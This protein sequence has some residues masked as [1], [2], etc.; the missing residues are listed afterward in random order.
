MLKHTRPS[1]TRLSTSC[2]SCSSSSYSLPHG[3]FLESIVL[4]GWHRSA[5]T[6]GFLTSTPRSRSRP[7]SLSRALCATRALSSSASSGTWVAPP[8]RVG[9]AR[10]VGCLSGQECW[11]GCMRAC[12]AACCR[13]AR[14][15]MLRGLWPAGHATMFSVTLLKSSIHLAPN[16]ECE[17]SNG[18]CGREMAGGVAVSCMG[19]L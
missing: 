3:Q 8:P 17:W 7:G 6:A 16:P 12:H 11:R 13:D 15:G 1:S 5:A 18:C 19:P 4:R 9:A 2:Y 10:A 14:W